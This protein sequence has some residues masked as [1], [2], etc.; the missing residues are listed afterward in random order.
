MCALDILYI[1][2]YNYFNIHLLK[3]RGAEMSENTKEHGNESFGIPKDY[4]QKQRFSALKLFVYIFIVVIV[5]IGGYKGY[6]AAIHHFLPTVTFDKTQQP[7]IY[8]RINDITLKTAKGDSFTAGSLHDTDSVKPIQ[9]GTAV[10]FISKDGELCASQLASDKETE[11]ETVVI[12]SG[13]SDFKTN[14]DGAF[15]AY[16]KQSQLFVSNLKVSRLL[17]SDISE[18]YLSKNNQKVIFIKNDNSIYTKNCKRRQLH[19]RKSS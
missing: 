1:K 10:F 12:D 4:T 17:A 15:V 16:R 3:K 8:Q 19:G 9:K 5:C 14:S 11:S 2:I 18:Y 13:V 7:I 6:R